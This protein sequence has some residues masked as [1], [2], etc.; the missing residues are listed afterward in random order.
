MQTYALLFLLFPLLFPVLLVPLGCAS[1]GSR[2]DADRA[3]IDAAIEASRNGDSDLAA[4]LAD[5]ASAKCAPGKAGLG[6]SF[7]TRLALAQQFAAQ[8]DLEIAV[9]QARSASDLAHADGDP[10]VQYTALGALATIA[11][12]AEQVEIAE[13]ALERARATIDEIIEQSSPAER[14][15][16]VQTRSMLQA[17]QARILM[18]K[19]D[20]EAA[21]HSQAEVVRTLQRLDPAHR[22][23]PI[24]LLNLAYMHEAAGDPESAFSAL[25]AAATLAAER[26]DQA[27]RDEAL[28][29]IE[30]LSSPE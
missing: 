16:L 9:D 15:V 10:V 5:A 17:P 25:Q 11:A 4:T 21:A 7:T 20:P 29:A 1:S 27:V 24:E 19:G 23:L 28:A 30:A 2:V 3:A 14:E 18:S 8:G 26:G 22:S 6:C 13:N 12:Q